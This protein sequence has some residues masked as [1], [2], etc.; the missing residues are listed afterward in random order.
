MIHLSLGDGAA[1]FDHLEPAQ[2]LDGFVGAF[3]GLFNGLL[4]RG[5]RGAGSST[6]L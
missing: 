6:S 1:C 5:G 4:D 3:N 2:V